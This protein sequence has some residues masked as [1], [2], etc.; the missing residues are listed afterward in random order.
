MKGVNLAFELKTLGLVLTQNFGYQVKLGLWRRAGQAVIGSFGK[1]LQLHERCQARLDFLLERQLKVEL[2][3]RRSLVLAS[4]SLY[5]A[6]PT[7][8]TQHPLQ[9][10]RIVLFIELRH[11]VCWFLSAIIKPRAKF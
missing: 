6:K 8:R 4:N 2:M 5:R 11:H 7:L 10:T 3:H 1:F 9:L